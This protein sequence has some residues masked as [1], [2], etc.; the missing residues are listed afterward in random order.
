MGSGITAGVRA[1]AVF[2]PDNAGPAPPMLIAALSGAPSLVRWTGTSWVA[3]TGLSGSIF[4]VPLWDLQV[5]DSDGAGPLPRFSTWP[6]T[7]SRLPD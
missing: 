6:E 4:G 2:D 1:F 5:F 3:I 7:S